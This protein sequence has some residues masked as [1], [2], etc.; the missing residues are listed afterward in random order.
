MVEEERRKNPSSRVF[1]D[2]L[3]NDGALKH[4]SLAAKGLWDHHMLPAA[5]RSPQL[6][7]VIIEAF[8][9][10]LDVDLPDRLA[11]LC[12]TPVAT[13]RD[14]LQELI[15]SGAAS[16]NADGRIYN[17]RMVREEDERIRISELRS[18]AGKKGA[19]AKQA[20]KQTVS[21]TEAKDDSKAEANEARPEDPSNHSKQREKQHSS[22]SSSQ[23]NGNQ[24]GTSKSKPS[25]VFMLQA[26]YE[27]NDG[28]SLADRSFVDG[29]DA[30]TGSPPTDNCA[31]VVALW[32]RTADE[33]NAELGRAEWPRVQK[34]T[35]ARL[36]Q[37]KQRLRDAGGIGGIVTALARARADPWAR[38]DKQRPAEHADWRFNFDYFIK[39]K[40]FTQI[41]EKPDEPSRRPT[42]Q[43]SH[44]RQRQALAEWSREG[45]GG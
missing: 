10:L 42:Q 15:D 13:V 22:R 33:L 38:G 17:R 3:E 35:S 23:A 39:E 2:D 5:A 20:R 36:R 1:W 37:V 45:D 44:E 25:S 12:N 8:P 6:G 29:A 7:V 27:S 4:C 16:V 30:P 40:T 31:E 24:N 18:N 11:A 26:S 41:M 34:L 32:N 28:E 21:K 43:S 19:E 14:L 9:S